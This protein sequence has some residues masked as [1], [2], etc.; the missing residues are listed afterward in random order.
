M[1]VK[2]KV[3]LLLDELDVRQAQ[4]MIHTIIGSFV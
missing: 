1:D 3:S 4:V 2:D